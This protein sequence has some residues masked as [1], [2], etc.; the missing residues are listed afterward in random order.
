VARENLGSL[1]LM[2]RAGRYRELAA[3]AHATALIAP[4]GLFRETYRNIAKNWTELAAEIDRLL[5]RL[6]IEA[7]FEPGGDIEQDFNVSQ[8]V[9]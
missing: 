9:H 2:K 7:Y 4:E 3:E 1:P 5:E 6:E 8:T